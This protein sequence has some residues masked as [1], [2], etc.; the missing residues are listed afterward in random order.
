MVRSPHGRLIAT[1]LG[2]GR[3]FMSD[4]DGNPVLK[5]T[6]KPPV[7]YVLGDETEFVVSFVPHDLDS[8]GIDE[9]YIATT[10][11]LVQVLLQ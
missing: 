4:L 3:I 5:G 9:L 11:G 2:D 10:L 6:L 7:S 1:V 8:N